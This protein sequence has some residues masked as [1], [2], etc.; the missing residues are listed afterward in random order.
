MHS[1]TLIF[2]REEIEVI[3]KTMVRG[4]R[5]MRKSGTR[6]ASPDEEKGDCRV[7][8]RVKFRKNY[9]QGRKTS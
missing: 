4:G 9:L 5:W 6:S 1:F 3:V 8:G 2:L 7:G